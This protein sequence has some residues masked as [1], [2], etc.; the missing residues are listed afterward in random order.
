VISRLLSSA[1]WYR[2]CHGFGLYIYIVNIKK[3][4]LLFYFL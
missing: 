3:C 2:V 1:T 4:I